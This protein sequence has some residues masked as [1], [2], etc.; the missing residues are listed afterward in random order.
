MAFAEVEGNP[1]IID[2]EI[3]EN[4]AILVNLAASKIVK[5]AI[6]CN[7]ALRTY[8]VHLPIY[9]PAKQEYNAAIEN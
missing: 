2:G 7:L 5:F 8:K 4:H 9:L 6:V 3:A 1:F